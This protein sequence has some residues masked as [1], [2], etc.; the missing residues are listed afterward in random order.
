M[1][2][3]FRHSLIPSEVVELYGSFSRVTRWQRFCDGKEWLNQAILDMSHKITFCDTE[4]VC[5]RACTTSGVGPSATSGYV[6]Y[7]AAVEG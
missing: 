3:T 7:S 5:S 2:C 6:R 4:I 1:V